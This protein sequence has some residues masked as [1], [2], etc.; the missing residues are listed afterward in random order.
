MITL[1]VMLL[2]FGKP[3]VTAD[4]QYLR[5][6]FASAAGDEIKAEQLINVTKNEK[7]NTVIMAYYGVG[8]I[9]MANYYFNPMSKYT[10]FKEG[11]AILE[12][13]IKA[14]CLNPELRYLRLTIQVN[15]P[16][17]LGYNKNIAMDKQY[18]EFSLPGLEDK[19]LQVMI[20]SFLRTL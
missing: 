16:A 12:A 8:K 3:A 15:A 17:F 7:T 10:S 11:K 20:E 5:S 19:Q 18:L 13:A 14:D 2:L 9:L 1:S 4:I 6:L